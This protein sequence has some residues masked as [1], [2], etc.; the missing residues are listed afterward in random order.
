MEYRSDSTKKHLT[1]STWSYS[2][3]EWFEHGPIY[4]KLRTTYK[5]QKSNIDQYYILEAG[6]PYLK[7]KTHINWQET[8]VL[9]KANFPLTI[10]SDEA[11]YE[12][13]FGAIARTTTPR[14]DAEKAQWEVPALRWADLSSSEFGA[15]ILTNCKHGFDAGP[16]HL[17]LTLLKSPIWPDPN[18]DQG[19]HTFTY[20]IYPH[21]RSWQLA[22]TAQL[23]RE[24]NILP[25]LYPS[26]KH[27]ER[28]VVSNKANPKRS[29]LNI[30]NQNV[31][32]SALKPREDNEE[33]I[34]LRCYETHGEPAELEIRSNLGLS[35]ISQS[36]KLSQINLIEQTLSSRR[37]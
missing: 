30:K 27:E 21:Q 36:K 1:T 26:N 22:R 23:A 15:S 3:F 32:L 19:Q 28:S 11:T 2:L 29:F 31:I 37:V 16:N 12:I 8:Q 14:T 5:F 13:P 9:L 25:I 4:Q 10:S 17:R 7:I 33:D 35:D 18:A 6:S 34:I 24:L 20:A